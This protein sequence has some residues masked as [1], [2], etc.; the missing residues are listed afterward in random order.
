MI[1]HG[2]PVYVA[3]EPVDMRLGSERQEQWYASACVPSRGLARCSSWAA[4]TIDEGAWDVTG[5]I[6]VHKKLDAGRFSCP[7]PRARASTAWC[8][9]DAASVALV[10]QGLRLARQCEFSTS[11]YIDGKGLTRVDT[12][13]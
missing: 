1:D 2:L 9:N 12:G 10:P 8:G 4:R 7:E 13:S 5:V 6:V 3:L 11:V